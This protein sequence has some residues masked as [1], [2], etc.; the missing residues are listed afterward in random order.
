MVQFECPR[1]IHGYNVRR[2][3]QFTDEGAITHHCDSEPKL[4]FESAIFV[5]ETFRLDGVTSKRP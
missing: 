5:V 1:V 2:M 3:C 4:D